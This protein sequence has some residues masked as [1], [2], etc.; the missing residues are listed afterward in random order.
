MNQK[1]PI[2][3]SEDYWK[4]KLIGPRKYVWREDTIEKLAA[5]LALKPGMT[6]ID[7]GCGLGYLGYT[8]WPWYGQGGRYIGIDKS[9]KLLTDTRKAANEWA[10]DGEATFIRGDVYRL[11][12]GDDIADIVM[13]QTLLMHLER[14]E[15]ALREMVRVAKPGRLIVCLEPDNVSPRIGRHFSSMPQ[16]DFDDLLLYARIY[17]TCHEGRMKLGRGDAAI[18]PKV[19]HMMKTLAL[20]EIDIRIND[21]VFHLEPPYE[22]PRQRHAIEQLRKQWLEEK[23]RELWFQ[24]E[25]EE[26][27]AGGGDLEDYNRYR[28][29]DDRSL[30]LFREQLE[31]GTLY[32]CGSSDMYIIKGRKPA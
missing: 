27:L 1:K 23:G 9:H 12:S 32:S 31:N 16:L 18:G 14:P 28:E 24:R 19:P 6:V 17:L 21:R 25:K 5:W 22:S 4:D 29:I 8:Y 3:W 11:P 2:D 30:S 7:V 15:S 10:Q 26:F 13:C 20:T